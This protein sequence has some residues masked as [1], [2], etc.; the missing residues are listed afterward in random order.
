MKIHSENE[1]VLG[2]NKNESTGF[3]ISA[4]A[5]AFQ[6]LSSGIYKHKI[7]AVVRE[8]VCNAFDA[9]TVSNKNKKQII[10]KAP[11][12]INP[13][14]SVRDYGTGLSNDDM[15]TVYTRYFESTKTNSSDQIGAFG[16]GAK[17]PFSYTDTFSVTSFHNGEVNVYTALLKDGEPQLIKSYT[18][19]YEDGDMD[20]IEV[21]VPVKPDDIDKWHDEISRI[22]IPFPSDSYKPIG[23]TLNIDSFDK[24]PNYNKDYFY[25]SDWA[26]RKINA[27][28]GNIVY[29]I[30]DVPD[31]ECDW[32]VSNNHKLYIHFDMDT[33]IPQPSREEIQLDEYTISNIQARVKELNDKE[34]KRFIKESEDIVKTKHKREIQRF[35][36]NINSNQKQIL[37]N[38]GYTI[39]GEDYESYNWVID[40]F[41]LTKSAQYCKCYT[42]S[43]NPL[44][45]RFV[46]KKPGTYRKFK[47]SELE[48]YD[49][50]KCDN[51]RAFVIIDDNKCKKIREIIAGIYNAKDENLPTK[52]DIVAIVDSGNP[53]QMKF[54]DDL[55]VIME[56]DEVV[57]LYTSKL[58]YLRIKKERVYNYDS[59]E[60]KRPA[61]PNAIKMTYSVEHGL[62]SKDELF[63]S[64][65]EVDD[66]SGYCIGTYRDSLVAKVN[67]F[68]AITSDYNI[69]VTDIA[70]MVY[71]IAGITEFYVVRPTIQKRV[72]DNNNLLCVVEALYNATSDFIEN[73]NLD[74]YR[75]QTSGV[76]CV[77]RIANGKNLNRIYSYIVG[78]D[79]DRELFRFWEKIDNTFRTRLY[80]DHECIKRFESAKSVYKE[81]LNLYH[82]NILS[83]YSEFKKNN[84]TIAKVIEY[85]YNG[86]IELIEDIISIL[87]LKK[88]I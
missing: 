44:R 84:P 27:I 82:T 74:D 18:G 88:S 79:Y 36:K 85:A 51:K 81:N 59:S 12:K 66:L 7:R 50:V 16:L 20:G 49:L 3:T 39:D 62:C 68:G 80:G 42:I 33:I 60:N 13:S 63:L 43:D 6:I 65:K 55:K 8:V 57:V 1:V 26:H 32:L 70:H 37:K 71:K 4:S 40:P 9:H 69:N 38:L 22:M 29:D 52:N 87:E 54:V 67:N 31:L 86:E 10:I 61:S 48:L 19:P 21:V 72:F 34:L 46:Y 25:S 56:G 77:D 5:K 23:A 83:L 47:I 30:S 17:S 15:T 58:E 24:L 73:S 28:Y 53:D 11:N 64:S 76:K 35:V 2:N 41:Q 45:R 75:I 14:F 78:Y